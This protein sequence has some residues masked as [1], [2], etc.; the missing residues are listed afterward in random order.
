MEIASKW[1][2]ATVPI[3]PEEL[4]PITSL[5]EGSSSRTKVLPEK[6]PEEVLP[7]TSPEEPSSG[8]KNYF[9]QN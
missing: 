5:E 2:R 1:R 6:L 8:R 7:V 9:F 4:L 3:L